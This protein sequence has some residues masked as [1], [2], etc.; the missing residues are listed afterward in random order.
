[1]STA[2]NSPTIQ[3]LKLRLSVFRGRKRVKMIYVLFITTS[4]IRKNISAINN[5][6]YYCVDAAKKPLSDFTKG[7]N[8]AK[9]SAA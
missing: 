8:K 6:L 7:G 4:S 1:M 2:Y 9:P 3:G 5:V